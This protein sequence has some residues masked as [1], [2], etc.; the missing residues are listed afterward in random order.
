MHSQR[1]DLDLP[2]DF[3]TVEVEALHGYALYF[4]GARADEGAFPMTVNRKSVKPEHVAKTYRKAYRGEAV[5]VALNRLV[6]SGEFAEWNNIR[7]FLGHRGAPGG[8]F[9]TG[10]APPSGVDWNFPISRVDRSTALEPETLTAQ[11]E[12]LGRTVTELVVAAEA[13]AR[14]HVS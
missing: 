3:P 7:N 5:A 14:A 8:H 13:F 2:D 9:Y 1:F 12:W 6:G 11:R 4:V 10:G